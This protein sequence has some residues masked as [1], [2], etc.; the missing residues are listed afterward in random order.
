MKR[1]L[2]MLGSSLTMATALVGATP[3]Q[4]QSANGETV[5]EANSALDTALNHEDRAA[6]DAL[7]DPEFTWIF[8]DGHY[9][10]R[11]DTLAAMP[12]SAPSQTGEHVAVEERAYGRVRALEVSSG[13]VRV[14]R[15]WVM[16]PEGWRLLHMNEIVIAPPRQADEIPYRPAAS[17]DLPEVPPCTNPCDSVPYV[18][19]TQHTLDALRSWQ[20]QELG[21]HLMD[22][23]LWGSYVTDAWVGQRTG[24]VPDPKAR[25]IRLTR[26][27]AANGVER[28][29]QATV[30]QMRLYDLEDA[31]LMVSLTQGRRGKPQYRSRIFVHD[32]QRPDGS[33]RYKMAESYGQVVADAP[34]FERLRDSPAQR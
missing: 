15:I 31:V 34:I 25:R 19:A 20:Q 4:A 7:L 13:L 24:G 26:E 17:P 9:Y 18:P 21:S 32:G 16:H 28:N 11:S 23:E 33:D 27:R 30:L 8:A 10:G 12:A 29:A 14:L 5:I 22:M 6:L 1:M 3:A 2:S